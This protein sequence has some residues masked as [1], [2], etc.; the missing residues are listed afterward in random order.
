MSTRL[1]ERGHGGPPLSWCV[2]SAFVV[3]LFLR[4]HKGTFLVAAFPLKNL[5]F[6]LLSFKA[7]VLSYFKDF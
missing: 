7:L 2:E 4:G 5:F 3:N 1:A 6:H